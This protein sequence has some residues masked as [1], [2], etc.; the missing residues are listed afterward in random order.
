MTTYHK[1]DGKILLY[2]VELAKVR[3]TAEQNK[4]FLDVL[5]EI[6]MINAANY[7]LGKTYLSR[8]AWTFIEPFYDA[9]RG[10]HF[11]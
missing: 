9:A 7:V 10:L 4:D 1:V 2:A 3:Y 5:E 11:D 8:S 6:G